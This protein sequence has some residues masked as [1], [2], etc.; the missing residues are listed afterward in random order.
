MEFAKLNAAPRTAKGKG[1]ARKVRKEGMIPAVAYGRTLKNMPISV[2]PA[3]LVKHLQG[4]N[5]LNTVMQLEVDGGEKNLLVMIREFTHHP[6]TRKFL[7][8]DFIQVKLDEDVDVEVPFNTTGKP[9]G[10][11][12]GGV[13]HQIYR[14]LPLRCRPEAIPAFVSVDITSLEL[15]HATKV[16]DLQLPA[17]VSVRLPSEQSIV[18]IVAPE[19]EV[20]EE[21]VPGAAAPAAGAAAAPAAGA[22]AKPGAA[23]AAPAKADAKPAAKKK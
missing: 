11:A 6:I 3:A 7:H 18:S 16:H 9:L 23:A 14:K 5:G 21:A 8:A 19:K 22:A 4:P 12:Q 2:D 20:V 1:P 10:L 17:G 13:L 15:G